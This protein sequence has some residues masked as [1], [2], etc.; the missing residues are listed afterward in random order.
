LCLLALYVDAARARREQ[1][2]L[3]G[4]MVE[5]VVGPSA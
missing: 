2:S 5:H 4:Q 3:G 1:H